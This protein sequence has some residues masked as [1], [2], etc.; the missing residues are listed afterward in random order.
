[1]IHLIC[2][3]ISIASAEESS[4]EKVGDIIQV[5]IP[6]TAYLSTFYMNDDQGRK[7]FYYS[8]LTNLTVTY[9]MK[10][11]IN[12]PRPEGHGDYSFPSGHTSAAFQGATFIQ[13]RY[14]WK[15]GLPAYLCASYVGWSRIEGESD[16]HDL[17]D[18][19]GGGVVGVLS[20]IF[21]TTPYNGVT[22]TPIADSGYYGL[23]INFAW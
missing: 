2:F 15:Y 20:T 4:F 22:V 16:K 5:S 7:Q 6:A 13:K 18:V 3:K 14:G 8:F 12:K 11:A 1:M 23:N 21:F 17:T 9:G 10:Y 19:L